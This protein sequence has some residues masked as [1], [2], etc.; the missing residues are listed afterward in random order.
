M[1]GTSF[2][3]VIAGIG[4]TVG[5]RLPNVRRLIGPNSLPSYGPVQEPRNKQG[6]VTQL[7]GIQSE[8]RTTSQPTILRIALQQ[9]RR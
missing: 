1:R 7:L 3:T 8:T 6:I 9:S 2:L 4:T 5:H